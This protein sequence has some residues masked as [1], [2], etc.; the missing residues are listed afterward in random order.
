M[1]FGARQRIS[2]TAG[3]FQIHA[4]D[5]TKLESGDCLKYLGLRKDWTQL[6][7]PILDY[8]DIIYQNLTLRMRY[9]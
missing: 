7:L 4:S 8:G 2:S 5:G 6:F 9:L 3:N 1:L